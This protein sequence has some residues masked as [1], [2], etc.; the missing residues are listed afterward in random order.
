[1]LVSAKTILEKAR[2]GG[3]AV[4]AFNVNNMEAV[5]AVVAAAVAEKSPVIIQT[6]EGALN[7]AGVEMLAAMVHTAAEM[8]PKIP[9]A[10]HLDHGKNFP[11]VKKIAASGLYTSV[12][13]DGSSHSF[14]TNIKKTK[15]IVALAHKQR[16][17]VQVEAELGAI[18][19][20]EDLVN[21]AKEDAF[22]TDPE[23]AEIFVKETG[24]DSLAI[25]IGTVHGVYKYAKKGHLDFDRLREIKKRVK[26]PLVLHGASEIPDDLVKMANKY[27]AKLGG[28]KGVSN[29]LLKHAVEL[30]IN[31]VNID[32]D[33][34]IAFDAGVRKMIK[35]R[36]KVYDPRKILSIANE[37]MQKE[38]Q[39]KMKMLGSSKKAY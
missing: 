12:M 5:N 24:C 30:G 18:P 16:P 1:M 31:K 19:G 26:I 15:E 11:L 35:T 17:K 34:R 33:L 23:R 13:Y 14:K 27:G 39:D 3:Y 28:A 32:S 29:R 36:P 2:K 7:Y 8:H 37:L 4:P 6:S 9:I 38:A 10:F 21:V 22:M 25:S 20:Q